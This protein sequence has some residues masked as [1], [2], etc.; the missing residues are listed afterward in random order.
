MCEGVRAADSPSA[1]D[2]QRILQTYIT[3]G[4]TDMYYIHVCIYII[5]SL[6]YWSPIWCRAMVQK[7]MHTCMIS[8]QTNLFRASHRCRR[9]IIILPHV[10]L[11]AG[12][13][14]VICGQSGVRAQERSPALWLFVNKT[15]VQISILQQW[16][17]TMDA[18]V[19]LHA[20]WL[21]TG[22]TKCQFYLLTRAMSHNFYIRESDEFCYQRVCFCSLPHSEVAQTIY[23][24][25]RINVLFCHFWEHRFSW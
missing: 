15:L 6:V 17:N 12:E 23:G 11:R 3:L 2:Q 10:I 14:E 19:A 20:D 7:R 16:L 1:A 9:N 4:M 22:E 13:R 21:T 18:R 5:V 24:F 25:C 8:T